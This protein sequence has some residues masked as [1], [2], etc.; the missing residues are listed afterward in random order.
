VPRH[1]EKIWREVHIRAMLDIRN[2]DAIDATAHKIFFAS[3]S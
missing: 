1:D 2:D 3:L